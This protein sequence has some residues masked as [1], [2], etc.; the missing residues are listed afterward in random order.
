MSVEEVADTPSAGVRCCGC[1][2][3]DGRG[4]ATAGEEGRGA[5]W[6]GGCCCCAVGAVVVGF[7][8]GF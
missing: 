5:F 3:A 8:E 1:G 7:G 6:G 2:V 4:G